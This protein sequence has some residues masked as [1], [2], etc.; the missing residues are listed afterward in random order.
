M[1]LITFMSD[2]GE[3]DHFVAVVKATIL[4]F[5][6]SVQIIDISH[7]I[8]PFN[9]AQAAFLL[10]SAY[11]NFPEGT[12]HL[13]AVDTTGSNPEKFIIAILN[14]HLFV[15]TDNG[16]VS[17]IEDVLPEHVYEINI[18]DKVP[19]TFPE[20]NILA[21]TAALLASG[22]TPEQLGKRL[23]EYNRKMGRQPRL[24]K[25]QIVGNVVHIDHYGN[26]YTNIEKEPF[27]KI[28]KERQYRIS[29]ARESLS[30]IN[31][32]YGDAEGGDCIAFF[33][34]LG[35]LELAINKGNA[36]ELLGLRYDSPINILFNP[37]I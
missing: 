25:N 27:E 16:L 23:E 33:N 6:P 26:L 32:G 4:T 15:L 18:S 31:K 37:E 20:K 10:K 11:K 36:A 14:K 24:T 34:D 13:V 8:E 12:I 28:R 35:L 7:T 21:Q 30:T 3:S 1:A 22:K 17:L 9:I 2:L 19:S 5:N 29:F